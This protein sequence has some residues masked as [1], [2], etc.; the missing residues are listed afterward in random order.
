M[1]SAPVLIC[2]GFRSRATPCATRRRHGKPGRLLV[3]SDSDSRTSPASAATS[4]ASNSRAYRIAGPA[5]LGALL[6]ELP[7][8]H[9][10][11]PGYTIRRSR[12]NVGRVQHCVHC[13]KN[14]LGN[15]GKSGK[16]SNRTPTGPPSAA[17]RVGGVRGL[18]R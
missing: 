6:Q 3:P 13:R 17:I 10:G 1:I 14:A 9:A 12:A 18:S 7:K 5:V 16:Y 8:Q 2:R 4:A 15:A 11:A